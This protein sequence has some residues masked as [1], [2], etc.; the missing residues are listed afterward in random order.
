MHGEI[1]FRAKTILTALASLLWACSALA[2]PVSRTPLPPDHPL[3]GS[4]RLDLPSVNCYEVYDLRA[5]GTTYVTS[6]A[7]VGE[8]EFEL[9]LEPSAQGF[10][11]WVDKITKDNGRPDCMG[12]VMEIGQVATNFILLH[13]SGKEF[14]LCKTEDANACIGPFVRLEGI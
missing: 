13:P 10:Y 12:A 7:E 5:D 6:G 3:L 8:S 9:S 11:K 2:Q 14:L 1:M 4:W